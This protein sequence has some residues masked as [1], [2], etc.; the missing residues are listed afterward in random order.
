MY[1]PTS[2]LAVVLLWLVARW[3]EKSSALHKCDVMAKNRLIKEAKSVI[4]SMNGLSWPEMTDEQKEIYRCAVNIL[5]EMESY[6][7]NHAP[8]GLVD[9]TYWPSWF[10][11][12]DYK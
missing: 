9:Q 7:K 12:R 8:A 3:W 4:A 6:R 5:Q 2:V 10:N 1:I 11:S